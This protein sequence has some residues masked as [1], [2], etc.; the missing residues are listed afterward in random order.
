MSNLGWLTQSWP[1]SKIDAPD[2][3]RGDVSVY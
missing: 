2:T 3:L 1:I